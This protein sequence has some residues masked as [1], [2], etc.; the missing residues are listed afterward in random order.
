MADNTLSKTYDFSTVEERIY[1]WWEESG[2]FKAQ[3][4]TPRNQP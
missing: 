1:R 3:Q 4:R 2:Y